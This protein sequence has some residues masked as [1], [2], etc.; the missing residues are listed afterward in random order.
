MLKKIDASLLIIFPI[1]AVFLT[2]YFQT[3]F[4]ISIFLFFGLPSLW[5]SYRTPGKILKTLIFS[6]IFTLP[7]V[8]AIDYIAG[9]D[10]SWYV[11][12]IFP[13][14]IL[15][16]IPVEDFFFGFFMA[17]YT[18]IFYEHFLDKGKHNLVDKHMKYLIWP[19]LIIIASVISSYLILGEPITI[20][21]AYLWMGIILIIIPCL[22]FLSIF[23]KLLSKYVITGAYFF[24]L[25]LTLEL[26][27]L[28]LNHWTFPGSNFIGWVEIFNY[29][30]PF[31]ELFFWMGLSTISILSFFEFFDDDRK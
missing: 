7:M 25:Y 10:M 22:T 17:Y 2:L 24:L 6:L 16:V 29:R 30:F 18:V 8:L 9:G 14:R 3:N 5:F 13:F 31:E 19:F 28:E 23:P 15:D 11:N 1:I 21:Y 20:P 27:A 26:T 4:L 12:S